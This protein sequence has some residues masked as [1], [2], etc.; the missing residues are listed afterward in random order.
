MTNLSFHRV[1]SAVWTNIILPWD[2]RVG[3]I[4]RRP[5][6]RVE[7]LYSPADGDSKRV[8]TPVYQI[9]GYGP[10]QYGEVEFAMEF[11]AVE[12]AKVQFLF[13]AQSPHMLREAAPDLAWGGY[14]WD[15]LEAEQGDAA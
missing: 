13:G 14:D 5:H 8:E 11:T 6:G 12:W 9:T 4:R 10:Q 1:T 3:A 15:A 2:H 7:Y